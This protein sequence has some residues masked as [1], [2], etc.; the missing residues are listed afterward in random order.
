MKSHKNTNFAAYNK[1]LQF[2]QQPLVVRVAN[3][4]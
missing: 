1:V 3:V 4:N 2:R